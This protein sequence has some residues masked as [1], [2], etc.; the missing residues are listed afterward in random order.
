MNSAPRSRY[1]TA[2]AP[3]TPMSESALEMG[4][5]WMTRLIALIT[6]IA[7]NRKKKN[8]SM[9]FRKEGH[10][11]SGG[12]QVEHRHGKQERPGEAHELIVA[13]ARKGSANPDE[14]EQHRTGL[15]REPEQRNQDR[16]QE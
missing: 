16:L 7:A 8:G 9:L 6:A 5:V 14:K 2:S 12:Q 4:W 11:E 1:S 13:E 3:M 10:E 15:G